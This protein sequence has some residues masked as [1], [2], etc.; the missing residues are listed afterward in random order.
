[1]SERCETMRKKHEQE[2]TWSDVMWA[3]IKKGYPREEAA[4]RADNFMAR[5]ERERNSAS[6]LSA[7]RNTR[8]KGKTDD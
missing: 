7:I 4:F 5:R 3:W 2:L 1:M 6:P 8:P